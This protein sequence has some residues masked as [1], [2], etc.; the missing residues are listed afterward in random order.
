MRFDG[1]RTELGVGK[2]WVLLTFDVE[3]DY[4]SEWME[5][6]VPV[7]ES[8]IAEEYNGRTKVVGRRLTRRNS[9]GS[10]Y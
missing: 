9:S 4:V 1:G 10:S 7:R 2:I 3:L 6:H 5:L 8:V